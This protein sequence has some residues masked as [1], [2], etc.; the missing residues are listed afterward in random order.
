MIMFIHCIVSSKSPRVCIHGLILFLFF[1]LFFVTYLD[2]LNYFATL[3]IFKNCISCTFELPYFYFSLSYSSCVF[4]DIFYL[5]THHSH[6][7][8]WFCKHD[9]LSYLNMFIMTVLKS[10]SNKSNA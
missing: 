5:V 10:L 6:T 4:I 9:S 1:F 7:F 8:L 3:M 2:N